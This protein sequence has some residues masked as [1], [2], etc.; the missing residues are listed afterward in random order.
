MER[1][2]SS[3][4]P[5]NTTWANKIA[6]YCGRALGNKSAPIE[7]EQMPS[8]YANELHITD[9][10][11]ALSNA[12][13]HELGEKQSKH[14]LEDFWLSTCEDALNSTHNA[15]FSAAPDDI[16]STE[17]PLRTSWYGFDP[18]KNRTSIEPSLAFLKNKLK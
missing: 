12:E 15:T 14:K 10:Y 8:C 13:N 9:T 5:G 7:K 2:E 11:D 6:Q 16:A 4:T 17:T 1:M 3:C 18:H